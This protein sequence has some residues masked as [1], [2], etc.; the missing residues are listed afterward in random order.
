MGDVA[1]TV[2]WKC[3]DCGHLDIDQGWT[4][5]GWVKVAFRCDCNPTTINSED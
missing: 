1:Y 3:D 4:R 5:E 2:M